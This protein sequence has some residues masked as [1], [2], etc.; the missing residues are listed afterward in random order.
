MDRYTYI[1]TI[2]NKQNETPNHTLDTVIRIFVSNNSVYMVIRSLGLGK[3]HGIHL[4]K[5][6]QH[7]SA[8]IITTAPKN[9]PNGKTVKH[10]IIKAFVNPIM[11][12]DIIICNRYKRLY[13][14]IHSI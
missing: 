2:I 14:S 11:N 10:S 12:I 6:E 8:I 4:V 5:H 1:M 9:H 13:L 3:I 7:F